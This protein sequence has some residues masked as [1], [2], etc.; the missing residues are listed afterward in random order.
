[1]IC[2][3]SFRLEEETQRKAP[4]SGQLELLKYNYLQ[5]ELLLNLIS[6]VK[7]RISGYVQKRVGVL[8]LRVD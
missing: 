3:E 7:I 4:H 5:S 1:V 8:L 6:L 2:F